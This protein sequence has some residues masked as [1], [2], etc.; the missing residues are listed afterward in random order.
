M[1]SKVNLM[2]RENTFKTSHQHST[3]ITA[4]QNVLDTEIQPKWL[5]QPMAIKI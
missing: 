2:K 1:Q 5:T 3:D 4:V